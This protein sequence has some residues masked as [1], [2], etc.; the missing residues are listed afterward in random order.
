MR[1]LMSDNYGEKIKQQKQE[2]DSATERAREREFIH[3]DC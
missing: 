1:H 2:R 3:D